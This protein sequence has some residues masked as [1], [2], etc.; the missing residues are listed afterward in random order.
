[1]HPLLAATEHPGHSARS[2][3]SSGGV[4]RPA[5]TTAPYA[6]AAEPVPANASHTMPSADTTAAGNCTRGCPY[7]STARPSNGCPTALATPYTAASAPAR[8]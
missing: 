1:M 8:E 4:N 3:P 2:P 5:T 6:H 7:R